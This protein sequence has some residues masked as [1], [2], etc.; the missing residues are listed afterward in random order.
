[1]CGEG[2]R[3][4]DTS[5][6][7]STSYGGTHSAACQTA[8]SP[9]CLTERVAWPKSAAI[10]SPSASCSIPKRAMCFG[11]SADVRPR[12][13]RQY[14]RHSNMNSRVRY[15]RLSTPIR[16]MHQPI[17]EHELRVFRCSGKSQS[18]VSDA[19]P[20]LIDGSV[21]RPLTKIHFV[22]RTRTAKARTHKSLQRRSSTSEGKRRAK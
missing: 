15:A 11:K 14:L 6:H 7:C 9:S 3:K 8:V 20:P 2:I 18:A 16:T 22:D 1:M 21:C 4:S 12:P 5:S 17:A 13:A 10:G 19:S